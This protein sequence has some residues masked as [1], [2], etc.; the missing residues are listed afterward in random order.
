MSV[1][2]AVRSF[3]L[4]PNHIFLGTMLGT[5]ISNSWEQTDLDLQE[6]NKNADLFYFEAF[7]FLVVIWFLC[8]WQDTII[9]GV[10]SQ[11]LSWLGVE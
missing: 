4:D 8:L 3:K 9:M 6:H 1:V 7:F 10:A 11:E 2:L 5:K